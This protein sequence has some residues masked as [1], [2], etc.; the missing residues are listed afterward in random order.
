MGFIM[1]VASLGRLYRIDTLANWDV[2]IS[3]AC[4]L[5]STGLDNIYLASVFRVCIFCLYLEQNIATA[6]DQMT[7]FRL[8][9]GTGLDKC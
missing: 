7:Y 8:E 1:R 6:K 5:C 3:Q 4:S 2:N 9:R